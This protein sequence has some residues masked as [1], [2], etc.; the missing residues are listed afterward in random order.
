MLVKCEN[1]GVI[2]QQEAGGEEENI[3]GRGTGLLEFLTRSNSVV[4]VGRDLAQDAVTGGRTLTGRCFGSGETHCREPVPNINIHA[5]KCNGA[6]HFVLF[7]CRVHFPFIGHV[8]LIS[9]RQVRGS[10]GT[11]VYRE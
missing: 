2:I 3:V 1:Y 9:H 7:S 4:V 11:F 8:H 10:E 5:R 6:L